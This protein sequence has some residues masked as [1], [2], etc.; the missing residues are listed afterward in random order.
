MKSPNRVGDPIPNTYDCVPASDFRSSRNGLFVCAMIAAMTA[1]F[2]LF[3]LVGGHSVEFDSLLL[4]ALAAL[5]AVIALVPA[6]VSMRRHVGKLDLF[7]PLF[8]AAWF[9]FIPQFVLSSFLIV[10]GNLETSASLLLGDPWKPRLQ[11]LSFAILGCIGL[12]LGYFLPIG[13]RLGQRL[14]NYKALNLS[15]EQIKLPLAILLAVGVIARLSAFNVGAFGYQ[16]NVN[17]HVFGAVFSAFSGL[18]EIAHVIIWYSFYKNKSKWRFWVLLSLG[19]ILLEV[20]LSGSRGLLFH[21]MLLVVAGYQYTLKTWRLRDIIRWG[22]I[23]ATGLVIG[24]IFGSIFRQVKTQT[25]GRT[26]SLTVLDTISLSSDVLDSVHRQSSSSSLIK[27]AGERIAERA[28]GISSL[29]VIVTY[30]D[31][32]KPAEA[33]AGIDNNIIKDALVSIVPRFLWPSKPIVGASEIIGNI[34]FGT[35]YSSPATTYMG[36]LYRNFGVWGIVPGMLVL[37]IVLRS[38]YAWLIEGHSGSPLRSALF[39]VLGF[40]VNYESLYS[41]YFPSLIRAF[42]ITLFAIF[43]VSVFH[44]RI[45][46]GRDT[47]R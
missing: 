38:L 45:P 17:I 12:T 29:A 23:L 6:F 24:M 34:Y 33:A 35:Q 25:L 37:G 8:Y 44:K 28:D 14:P 5:L 4:L 21:S 1:L 3:I 31:A 30:A 16:F 26:A 11:A 19:I 22:F 47:T 32:L 43:I 36:D 2:F 40:V 13:R 9:F 41:T 46:L 10:F 20:V 18:A 42:I 7:H 39:M 27:Y 15:P